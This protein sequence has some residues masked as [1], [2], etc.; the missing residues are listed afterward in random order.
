MDINIIALLVGT[1]IFVLV[2]LIAKWGMGALSV[3]AQIIQVVMILIGLLYLLWLLGQ[4]GVLGMLSF[5]IGST[6]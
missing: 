2:A 6:H 1:I 4:L 5:H 3:P